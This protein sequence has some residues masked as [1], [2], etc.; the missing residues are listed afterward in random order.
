MQSAWQCNREHLILILGCIYE[1]TLIVT[2]VVVR[3]LWRVLKL[4]YRFTEEM[5]IGFHRTVYS[6]PFIFTIVLRAPHLIVRALFFFKEAV[7]PLNVHIHA[8]IWWRKCS[9]K[10]SYEWNGILS[11][12]SL[13]PKI[14]FTENFTKSFLTTS[15]PRSGLIWMGIFFNPLCL[16]FPFTYLSEWYCWYH[17][18]VKSWCS[19]LYRWWKWDEAHGNL[20]RSIG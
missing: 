6:A 16:S 8:H 1:H 17:S 19:A 3:I 11:Y 20:W 4:H 2:Y 15:F 13:I 5:H 14:R 9:A 7:R 18:I 12:L 10:I